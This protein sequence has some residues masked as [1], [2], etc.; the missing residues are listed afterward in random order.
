MGVT[1]APDWNSLQNKPSIVNSFNGSTGAVTGVASMNGAT[2]A[3]T[4]TNAYD[5][6]SFV[7]GRPAN[8]T[9]YSVGATIAGSS[10]YSTSTVTNS[11]TNAWNSGAGQSLINTGSWRCV[12]AAF[13]TNA[14]DG[15]SGLWVRYA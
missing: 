5:I 15:N 9:G 10:L 1:A 12:S 11:Y 8:A 14:N 6:G 2:G 13:G 4:N 3:V 7:I